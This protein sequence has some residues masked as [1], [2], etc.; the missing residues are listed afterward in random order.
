MA[1]ERVAFHDSDGLVTIGGHVDWK[2]INHLTPF[3]P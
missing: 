1:G 2:L 3:E